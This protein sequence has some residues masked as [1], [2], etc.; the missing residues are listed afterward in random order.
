MRLIGLAFLI[1][2]RGALVHRASRVLDDSAI[3]NSMREKQGKVLI[4]MFVHQEGDCRAGPTK[5]VR[6]LYAY[7]SP[8]RWGDIQESPYQRIYADGLRAFQKIYATSIPAH[9]RHTFDR[10]QLHTS[11]FRNRCAFLVDEGRRVGIFTKK[12]IVVYLGAGDSGGIS[13][14]LVFEGTL[15]PFLLE[16]DEFGDGRYE[17]RHMTELPGLLGEGFVRQLHNPAYRRYWL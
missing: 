2:E 11:C 3:I 10:T 5:R 7:H 6:N 13:A 16:M 1:N 12:F 8:D 17:L 15:V 14:T 9:I 4:D